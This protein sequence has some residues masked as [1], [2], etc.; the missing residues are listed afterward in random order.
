[1][2]DPEDDLAALMEKLARPGPLERE[3]LRGVVNRMRAPK[4]LYIL[5][6]DDPDERSII[7]IVGTSRDGITRATIALP[8]FH[9]LPEGWDGPHEMHV[10]IPLATITPRNT[11]TMASPSISELADVGRRLDSARAVGLFGP[12]I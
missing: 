11:A 12:Q 1:M 7:L 10:A 4:P 6:V 2:T 9:E 8:E 3:F 5:N